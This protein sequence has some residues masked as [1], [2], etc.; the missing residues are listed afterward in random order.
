MLCMLARRSTA[1]RLPLQD[2]LQLA[3]R[4]ALPRV[5]RDLEVVK[6]RLEHS[7]QRDDDAANQLVC[8]RQGA[9][10]VLQRQRPVVL[11]PGALVP[12]QRLAQVQAE[13]RP[14]TLAHPLGRHFQHHCVSV[15]VCTCAPSPRQAPPPQLDPP[16]PI[17]SANTSSSI[18]GAADVVRGP[19]WMRS[20]HTCSATQRGGAEEGGGTSIP[21]R[22]VLCRVAGCSGNSEVCGLAPAPLHTTMQ[23][24]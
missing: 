15:H 2:E 10:A 8:G 11:P 24:L 9:G 14:P 19:S 16:L 22:L 3:R 20:F 13:Q 21:L 6:P 17:F 18:W 4:L 5:Q 1:I 23:R 7:A 12:E